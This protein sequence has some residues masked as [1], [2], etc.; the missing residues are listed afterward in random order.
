MEG[1]GKECN[2]SVKQDYFESCNTCIIGILEIQN[3]TEE[4]YEVIM[5]KNDLKLVTENKVKS[6]NLRKQQA[7]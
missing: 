7:G 1:K 5:A 4:I 2:V 3:R 6:R